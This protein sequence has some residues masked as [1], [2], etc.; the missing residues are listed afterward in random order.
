MPNSMEFEKTDIEFT[1][2]QGNFG[3]LVG[4]LKEQLQTHGRRT[5]QR[6]VSFFKH[7]TQVEREKEEAKKIAAEFEQ[8]EASLQAESTRACETLSHSRTGNQFFCKLLHV[9]LPVGCVDC[10]ITGS[11]VGESATTEIVSD[12]YG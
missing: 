4:L 12:L 3:K 6:T 11:F 8:K 2:V 9:F 1:I 5:K 7:D 10:G